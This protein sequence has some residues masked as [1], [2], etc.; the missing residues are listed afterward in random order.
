[1]TITQ[2]LANAA[3]EQSKGDAM[4][5]SAQYAVEHF[6]GVDGGACG[7]A[8]VTFYPTNKGNTTLGK[9]E[10][11][12]FEKLGFTKDYT[13]KAW[14]LWNP[15]NWGGQSVDTKFAGARVYADTFK[16]ITGIHIGCADRLD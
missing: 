3:H 5:A 2:E 6:D 16:S 12:M 14:T 15:G 8:W 7:F 13:G 1:M 4:N 10:R 9:A 11:K